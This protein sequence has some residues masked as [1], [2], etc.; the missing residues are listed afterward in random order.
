M[1]NQ[2]HL[3]PAKPRKGLAISSLVL[4]IIGIP[5]F[6]LLFV[7]GIAG[8]ILGIIALNKAK[9]NP[10][11]YAGKGLATAGIVTS[12]LS[13]FI[14]IPAMMIAAIAIPNLLKAQQ[15]ARE[16][17]ALG[18]VVAIGQAQVLYSVTR[19]RGKFTDLRTLGAEGLIDSALAS[20]QKGGYLFSSEP[21][22]SDS[23]PQMFDTTAKPVEA[24]TYGVGNRSFG[25]NE[26]L[27]LY[28]SGGSVDL[29]GTRDNRI[30]AG[31][32][33]VE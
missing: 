3:I 14:A 4:G 25:S 15:A 27:I 10:A 28:E 29:K 20:G 13:L 1:Q 11:Q 26:T 32:T 30:P 2:E 6:G 18:E 24:G 17:E 5:T 16:M 21:V 19:G 12:V 31:A 23:G 9:S 22:S 33:L 8:I 7:G